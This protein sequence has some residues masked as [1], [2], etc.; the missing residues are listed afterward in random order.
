MAQVRF[1]HV[2][3]EE[4]QRSE[5]AYRLRDRGLGALAP[6]GNNW[7]A[8]SAVVPRLFSVEECRRIM[9]YG[10]DLDFRPGTM[11]RP[12]LSARRCASAW[13]RC[14]DATAW[15]YERVV[16]AV[17]EANHNY[18]FDLLGMM[19]P[20]QFLRYDAKSADEI[21]WHMDCGEGPNTTRKLSLTVQLSDPGDYGGGDLEF[22]AL[23]SSSFTRHQGAAILFPALLAHRVTPVTSGIRYS[24]VAFFNGPPFR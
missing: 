18:A 15:I 3:A 5:W 2:H 4:S 7:V 12:S 22:L 14:N 20:F 9:A 6:K 13:M 11:V 17:D 16:K 23:P 1:G 8:A 21:G 19:D 10:S 24:L